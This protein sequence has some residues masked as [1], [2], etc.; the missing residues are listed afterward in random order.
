MELFKDNDEWEKI[1][2]HLEFYTMCISFII[3]LILFHIFSR[4]KPTTRFSKRDQMKDIN[5][6][7]DSDNDSNILENI[8]SNLVGNNNNDEDEIVVYIENVYSS[9]S[10]LNIN[11]DDNNSNNI[12]NSNNCPLSIIGGSMCYESTLNCLILTAGASKDGLCD[13]VHV[14]DLY[15]ESWSTYPCKRGNRSD[16]TYN[17]KGVIYTNLIM[18]NNLLIRYGG[19]STQNKIIGELYSFD[20]EERKWVLL[21]PSSSSSSATILP[22]ARFNA[23]LSQIENTKALLFGGHGENGVLLNDTWILEVNSDTGYVNWT[24]II[25]HNDKISPPTREGHCSIFIDNKVVI[26]GGA[27]VHHDYLCDKIWIMN[28]STEKESLEWCWEEKD[29]VGKPPDYAVVGGSAYKLD[30]NSIGVMS[31]E[32]EGLFNTL[33]LLSISSS[34]SSSSSQP[35]TWSKPRMKWCGDWSA[36]P[37]IRLHH[38]GALDNQ[39][40][41]IYIFG[42]HAGDN[43][44]KIGM[45]K[46][47]CKELINEEDNIGE[48]QIINISKTS[49]EE[50]DTTKNTI[51]NSGRRTVAPLPGEVFAS[52]PPSSI[53]D[54]FR[55]ARRVANKNH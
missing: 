24:Q 34:S 50:S 32:G 38:A 41:I 48:E 13:D 36:I 47:D 39:T 22:P 45:N 49:S 10:S 11:V 31:C 29:T 15:E 26:I 16:N 17:H 25:Q 19:M 3:P 44:P 18:I 46:I 37:G 55:G 4:S 20:F 2:K 53:E 14:Y 12:N 8:E 42:G 43:C 35:Y 54:F 52:I 40:G 9:S 27:G 51:N 21:T 6:E 5:E 1:F 7:K 33:Y 28:T 30:Q 23:S